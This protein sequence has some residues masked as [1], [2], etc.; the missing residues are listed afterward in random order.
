VAAL[1]KAGKVPKFLRNIRPIRL[2]FT[3][4]KVLQKLFQRLIEEN[5]LFTASQFAFRASQSTA[6]QC[7]SHTDNVTTAV[8]YFQIENTRA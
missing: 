7:F 1:Q 5:N 6:L 4:C 3:T 8:M 2:L